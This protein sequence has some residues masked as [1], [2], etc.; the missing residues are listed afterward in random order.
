MEKESKVRI[1]DIPLKRL[2]PTN[3]EEFTEAQ[4]SPIRMSMESIN[5]L[6]PLVVCEENETA[7]IIDGNKRY[8][9]LLEAGVE[10]VPCIVSVHRI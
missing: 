7:L 10:S 8:F 3:S 5:M 9:I 2:V 1:K 4:L 6:E